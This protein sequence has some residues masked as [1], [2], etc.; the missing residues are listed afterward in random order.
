MCRVVAGYLA[1]IAGFMQDLLAG[2]DITGD[3]DLLDNGN[4]LIGFAGPT[5]EV[6]GPPETP[7]LIEVTLNNT[8]VFNAVADRGSL[9]YRAEKIDLYRGY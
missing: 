2:I 6:K 1:L 9:E 8:E 5:P 4:Y 3:I 7:R